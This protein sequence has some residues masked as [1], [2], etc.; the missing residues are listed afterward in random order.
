[1][2][3]YELNQE[4]DES[5]EQLDFDFETGEVGE[6]YDELLYEKVIHLMQDREEILQYLAKKALNIRADIEAIKSEE[7]R[8]AERR[9]RF[10]RQHDGL[11]KVLDRE[12]DGVKTDLGVA[13]VSY[14]NSVQ[15]E[16]INEDMCLDWLKEHGHE[17]AITIPD[18]KINKAKLK[19]IHKTEETIPGVSFIPNRSC[20]LR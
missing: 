9:K 2:K 5:M 6:N 8:L 3:L 16:I 20:S 19:A 13:T 17:D 1:M 15:T 10:Q 14:R 7:E 12:C 4:I 18:P 11:I